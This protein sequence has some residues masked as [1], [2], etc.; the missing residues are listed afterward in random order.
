MRLRHAPAERDHGRSGKVQREIKHGKTHAGWAEGRRD[1]H[2]FTGNFLMNSACPRTV[3]QSKRLRRETVPEIDRNAPPFSGLHNTTTSRHSAPGTVPGMDG[4]NATSNRTAPE[5]FPVLPEAYIVPTIISAIMLVG[6]AGNSLVIFVIVRIGEMR[7][8]TNYYIV[9]LAT[10]DLAFLVLCLPFTAVIYAVPSWP[11]GLVMCKLNNYLFQI[12]TL[13][14]VPGRPPLS[15]PCLAGLRRL[16]GSGV[17]AIRYSEHRGLGQMLSPQTA[18]WALRYAHGVISYLP[19]RSQRIVSKRSQPQTKLRAAVDLSDLVRKPVSA[20]PPV[21]YSGKSFSWP[22]LAL[23]RAPAP[24]VRKLADRADRE[25]VQQTSDVGFHLAWPD[26]DANGGEGVKRQEATS[27]PLNTGHTPSHTG[28]GT[29]SHTIGPCPY[30]FSKVVYAAREE[31][32]RGLKQSA[33]RRRSVTISARFRIRVDYPEPEVNRDNNKSLPLPPTST[34]VVPTCRVFNRNTG[35]LQSTEERSAR[36]C[37]VHDPEVVYCCLPRLSV[38][39]MSPQ[40]ASIFPKVTLTATCLTLAA[41]SMDRFCAIV[42]PI[43]S[44]GFRQPKTAVAVSIFIWM[45]S[46]LLSI[47]VAIVR[48]L[49]TVTWRG[50]V[51]V[52]CREPGWSAAAQSAYALYTVVF[53]YLIPL[54][55]CIVACAWNVRHLCRRARLQ[56]CR[57]E[58]RTFQTRR[59][60]MMV[61]GVVVLFAV[62]WLPNNIIN[63]YR[64]MNQDYK[65]SSTFYRMKMAALCLS[66]AN[67]A[68]NPFVYTLVGENFRRN[69]RK[70]LKLRCGRQ[71]KTPLRG[72]M[73]VRYCSERSRVTVLYSSSIRAKRRC[74]TIQEHGVEDRPRNGSYLT[75]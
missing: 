25:R 27:R 15:D 26:A 30:S 50:H 37:F 42:L 48:D 7:T 5:P 2:P 56:A 71:N 20:I 18:A 3:I 23:L 63:L 9:N 14:Y 67:S 74:D 66:Y 31:T 59:V 47:P 22:Y 10:T 16:A 35:Q 46:F 40:G 13:G 21:S 75:V 51:M 52:L 12:Q 68:M 8:V 69:L 32:Y 11:F 60:A 29:P 4:D 1:I 45:V 58:Q 57:H 49:V 53:T 70:A 62:C 54:V 73:S 64:L 72:V 55:M 41:L 17:N 34:T 36:P 33:S 28:R 43:R 19:T 44:M 61:V 24:D 65:A 6:V 38:T 39:A